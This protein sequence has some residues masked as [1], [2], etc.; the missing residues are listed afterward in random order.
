MY[1]YRQ[2]EGTPLQADPALI[3]AVFG[4]AGAVG[5]GRGA[6]VLL[7]PMPEYQGWTL[8]LPVL[9]VVALHDRVMPVWT[10][11]QAHMA[12][13][14]APVWHQW[15]TRRA[16]A[17]Q[18]ATAHA[19]RIGT[20]LAA[21]AGV[22]AQRLADRFNAI[23]YARDLSEGIG[24]ARWYRGLG[25]MLSC[26]L[27]AIS[28]TPSFRP[29]VAGAASVT[30]PDSAAQY[31]LN[32]ILPLAY[33]AD[34]GARMGPTADVRLLAV[35]PDRPRIQTLA[36]LSEG[37]SL[38]G[39]LQRAGVGSGDAMQL[40]R[41]I[42]PE[43]NPDAIAPGTRFDLTL[44]RH[45]AP[46][47]PRALESARFRA[48]FDLNLAVVRHGDQ[49]QVIR[50]PIPVDATPLRI[51]GVIGGSLYQSARAAGA[52]LRAIQQ[53]LQ[54][55]DAHLSLDDLRQGA[56]FDLIVA[57][58]RTASGETEVGDLLYAGI[59]EDGRPRAQ[60]LRF[61]PDGQLFNAANMTEERTRNALVMPVA[62]AR[63]TSNYGLRY[64]PVL[65]Y[66]RMHSGTDLAAPWGAPVYAVAD[67]VVNFVGPHGGH[68]NYI[69]LEHG[70]ALA[71][72]YGH[73][74]RFAVGG[75]MRVRAGQ[76]IG[77]VGSTGLSTG[78]HLHYEVFRDGASI[79][80]MSLRFTVHA[81]VDKAQ[82]AAFR[83]ALAQVL[84]VGP[85]AALGPV[86][87]PR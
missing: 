21:R 19:R 63:I 80:P 75:G 35:M 12:V 23:D 16:R 87:A 66:T 61:G 10:R 7:P 28:M 36:T 56:T 65:G 43:I 18:Q 3:R 31:R 82:L 33:G 59:E 27:A 17:T 51:R 62:G 58:R 81:G 57:Y 48:R 11:V 37:D 40:A 84:R 74:S 20:P 68:G 25:V 44:G 54:A 73:L 2:I 76:V 55:V 6:T 69:R 41:L 34:V 72:G 50:Q 30:L 78:P 83:A 8:P 71:T 15:N 1:A 67:G 49:W 4:H 85:G 42:S 86:G 14:A 52:P 26:A 46:G 77:Y 47:M 32:T 38:I 79:D 29:M 53:Y 5:T 22:V 9:A 39:M 64:H 13:R 70:G 45:D 24:T 60:L